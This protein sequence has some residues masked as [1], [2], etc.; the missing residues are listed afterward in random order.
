[1]KGQLIALVGNT[2][3]TTGPHLHFEVREKGVPAQPEQVPRPRQEG[4]SGP[5]RHAQVAPAAGPGLHSGSPAPFHLIISP[6]CRPRWGRFRI[7]PP[8]TPPA[9]VLTNVLKAIFGSRNDRLL[10]QYR[11]IGR[12]H[13][14]PRARHRE[15]LRR[16]PRGEDAR[17]AGEGRRGHAAR[18]RPARGV[19]G[20]ARGLEARAGH[21]PLRR[22]ARRRPRAAPGQDRGD[23]HR[24]G[25][26]ARGHAA[27]LPERARPA[28]AST[29]SP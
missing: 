24:R 14:R 16:G 27:F 6:F 18:R 28:R 4:R 29:W 11:K 22:A 21:A 26:D 12:I 20:R 7:R 5:D 25:Q 8:P 3:R 9:P 23:A 1:M 10:K 15:A 19:R 2:G 17:A 13:Q